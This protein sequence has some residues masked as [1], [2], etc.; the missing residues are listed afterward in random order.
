M[1]KHIV[2]LTLIY[3]ATVEVEAIDSDAA[4]EY[5]KDNLE[6]LAPDSIFTRGEKTV[7]FADSLKE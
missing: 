7:D 4:V 1:N 6:D 2:T 5:V 3:N